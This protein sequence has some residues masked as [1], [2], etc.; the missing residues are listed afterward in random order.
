[1]DPTYCYAGS[2]HDPNGD[3][4]SDAAVNVA[5]HEITEATTDPEL[6]A[7]WDSAN[8]E[9]IGDLCA[10]MFGTTSWDGGLANQMW[11][12]DFYDLQL[13]YDNHASGCVQVGP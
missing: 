9:E 5:S 10:W 7:W 1:M 6:N 12:G 8:G 3:V 13:E 2:Q 11:N 4:P